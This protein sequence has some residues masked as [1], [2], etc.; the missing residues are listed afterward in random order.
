MH[1]V[2]TGGGLSLEE[3]SW[4]SCRTGFFLSVRVLSRL[5][6]RL[7]LQ[8]L[9]VAFEAGKLQFFGVLK[10]LADD[11]PKLLTELARREWVVY[12]KPPFGGPQQVI[13]YLGRY[14]HRVA[15]SNHRFQSITNHQI[16]FRYKHYRSHG[17]QKQRPM[18][19]R[20]DEFIRR[21]LMHTLPPGF[22]RIR[23]Y[24]LLASR[25]KA[26]TLDLCRRIL[27]PLRRLLPKIVPAFEGSLVSIVR[28]PVCHVG[29][30]APIEILP[31]RTGAPYCDSS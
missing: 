31:K 1:C 6:R 30:M 13:D 23:H 4:V 12:C 10:P 9:R 22:Q 29:G 19:L 3:S 27:D 18:R 28:C 21:F 25:N 20:P 11:F 15:I 24:G 7:L 8:A 5:F 16:V 14:T 2:V 17:K 26:A